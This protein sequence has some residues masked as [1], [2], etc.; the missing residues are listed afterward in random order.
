[1]S[2]YGIARGLQSNEATQLLAYDEFN[3]SAGNLDTPKALTLGGN[4]AEAS[5]V[6]A[7]GFVIDATN[8]QAQR[9]AV[10][11]ADLNSGCYAIAGVTEYTTAIVE[12]TVATSAKP[13]LPTEQMRLGVFARYS[14]PE[15]W[16]M[17]AVQ[18]ATGKSNQ[19]LV[20]T[21]RVA[22]VV[23]VLAESENGLKGKPVGS[24]KIELQVA[25]DGTWRAKAPGFPEL[26]GQ[27]V[28]LAT[29]GTLAKGKVGFYDA[30]TA[31]TANTRTVDSF[32]VMAAVVAGRVC[33]ASRKAEVRW[34]T[35]IRQ[36][37]T[38]TYYGPPSSYRGARFLVPP[39]SSRLAL[40]MRRNDVK[41][42]PDANV[43]DK[44]E[45]EVKVAERVLAP[46]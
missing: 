38:G 32:S 13:V 31:A 44:H 37:S 36:D 45:V 41:Q 25:A 7:N 17:A 28:A 23:T 20:V 46:R 9:S 24:T 11:D 40:K 35:T 12:A 43:T 6:G 22:G 16:L 19:R 21:K 10:S 8:H 14:S 1:M 34:D 39:G 27:D 5:K 29:G 26:S 33:F 18:T 4:W 42:E 15:N 2:G 30:W 3:Q